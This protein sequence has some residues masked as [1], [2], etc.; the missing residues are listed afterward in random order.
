MAA[1][2]MK[3][4]HNRTLARRFFDEILNQPEPS[5]IEEIVTED[6]RE[7]AKPICGDAAPGAVNG[8]DHLRRVVG[9]L[10]QTYP[11]IHITVDK[12]IAD[13]DEVAA[14][15]TASGT[16]GT[17]EGKHFSVSQ[18]H[19]F[20]VKDGRLGEHWAAREDLPMLVQLGMVE[21]PPM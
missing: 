13:G 14:Y 4:D 9:G 20:R 19:W 6:Y 11:D 8:P 1:A 5:A 10:H 21:C 2:Q 15:V 18:C 3:L 12:V 7:W 16:Q 17:G